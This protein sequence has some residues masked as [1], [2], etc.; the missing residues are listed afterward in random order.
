MKP[1]AESSLG[2]PLYCWLYRREV[3]ASTVVSS[4]NNS[5]SKGANMELA[6]LQVFRLP[7]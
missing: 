2:P 3:V 6:A 1:G 7:I 4:N 5:S